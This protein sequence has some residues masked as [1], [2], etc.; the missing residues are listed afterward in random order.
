[1]GLLHK[2]KKANKAQI[3]LA[4]QHPASTGCMGGSVILDKLLKN[5]TDNENESNKKKPEKKNK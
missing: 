5:V 3:E 2:I 4:M 1:M